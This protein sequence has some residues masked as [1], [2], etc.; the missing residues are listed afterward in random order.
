MQ[1]APEFE[2]RE[3]RARFW[4]PAFSIGL[5]LLVGLAVAAQAAAWM[6]W[7][8]TIRLSLGF[9]PVNY[10]QAQF[11]PAAAFFF[12]SAPIA[13]A[14]RWVLRRRPLRVV[15]LGPSGLVVPTAVMRRSRFIACSQI[16]SLPLQRVW[17]LRRTFLSI[18]L[19]RGSP[20]ILSEHRF[21]TPAQ[22]GAFR[23]AILGALD[24]LPGGSARRAQLEQR[25]R[26]DECLLG[27]PWLSVAVALSIGGL[28]WASQA[29]LV[30]PHRW[31]FIAG[32]VSNGDLFRV[33]TAN[34]LHSDLA[35]LAKNTTALL[36]FGWFGERVLGWQRMLGIGVASGIVGFLAALLSSAAPFFA[37]RGM[38]AWTYGW[39]G[40]CLW[41]CLSQRS[42]LPPLLQSR[43]WAPVAY[44]LLAALW[45]GSGNS[46]V[47]LPHRFGF[48]MGIVATVL[49]TRHWQHRRIERV[50]LPTGRWIVGTSAAVLCGALAWGL[51][52]AAHEEESAEDLQLL[53]RMALDESLDECDPAS[54]NPSWLTEK[55][56]VFAWAAAVD[57]SASREWLE[58][59][60]RAA[61]R[62]VDLGPWVADLGHAVEESD[63]L[64]TLATVRYRQ[65]DFDSAVELAWDAWELREDPYMAGFHLSQAARFELARSR[66]SGAQAVGGAPHARFEPGLEDGALRLSI[67]GGGADALAIHAV[68][69]ASGKPTAL[70]RV[71]VPGPIAPGATIEVALTPEAV[72]T[73]AGAEEIVTTRTEVA[74]ASGSG[75]VVEVDA[76]MQEALD[77]P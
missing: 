23:A 70:V 59:A 1:T 55:L 60:E 32:L 36:L 45:A 38:S 19:R 46:L 50:D 21:G 30:L 61:N 56:N 13:L 35:H 76:L 54:I 57:P 6:D 12:A 68:A 11:G 34:W 47:D 26:S 8:I 24:A 39:L 73:L 4:G 27:M 7:R 49:V 75:M 9:I 14:A 28:Y 77:L 51:V 18:G 5:A 71:K 74:L 62:A 40:A 63:Y 42:A 17:F 67:G 33:V 3:R 2:L 16:E 41:V 58:Q 31:A 15:R 52:D 69:M 72:A 25:S 37:A 53:L 43:I 44:L 22:L 29:L 64:D 65:G 20:T 48:A 66:A 10:Q